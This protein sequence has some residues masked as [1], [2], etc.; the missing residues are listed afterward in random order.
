M[1]DFLC[2]LGADPDLMDRRRFLALH[3]ACQFGHVG[4]TKVLLSHGSTVLQLNEVYISLSYS[5]QT[6]LDKFLR[7]IL[8]W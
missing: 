6:T 3:Y 4:V 7:L 8:V 5:S 1:A 2:Q